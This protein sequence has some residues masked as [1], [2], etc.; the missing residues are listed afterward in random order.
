MR[1]RNYVRLKL[2]YAAT[3]RAFTSYQV[4]KDD[5]GN[6]FNYDSHMPLPYDLFR[7]F[8]LILSGAIL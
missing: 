3:T 2:D 8:S 4:I 5:A 1:K 6:I 7:H